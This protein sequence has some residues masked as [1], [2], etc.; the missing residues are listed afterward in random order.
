MVLQCNSHF[1]SSIICIV[2]GLCTQCLS[3][4][5]NPTAAQQKSNTHVS[6]KAE[7]R[8][9]DVL[10]ALLI[11]ALIILHII[12]APFTKVEESFN[13]QATHDILAYG[14]PLRNTSSALAAHYDHVSFP[15][16]VPRTFVGP[17]LLAG[18]SWPFANIVQLIH[19]QILGIICSPSF[20]CSQTDR[21]QSEPF[22]GFSMPFAFLRTAIQSVKCS[23]EMSP[24]GSSSSKLANFTSCSMHP[25]LCR[26]SS[27][28]DCVRF[29]FAVL[30]HYL[31]LF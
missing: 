3:G 31:M 22:L 25:E 28:S 29:L 10:L 27:L 23:A 2:T 8:H 9:L 26:T 15:G 20:W 4:M 5:E 30:H 11:P 19:R 12:V 18:A 16:S 7:A 13:L 1:I 24:D 14:V 17:L 21:S 6:E